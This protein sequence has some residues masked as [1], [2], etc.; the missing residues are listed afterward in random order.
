MSDA[1]QI[2]KDADGKAVVRGR[3]GE[4]FLTD[5]AN[6]RRL[7]DRGDVTAATADQVHAH[8]D[9]EAG[10]AL[11]AAGRGVA[12]GVAGGLLSL[13]KAVTAATSYATGTEDPL[14]GLS[15]R[16]FVEDVRAIGTELGGGDIVQ[17][18]NEARADI[19]RDMALHPVA[20]HGGEIAGQIGGSA[21]Y[22]AG[23][24]GL[25]KAATAKAGLQGVAAVR[26][27]HLAAGALEG[28]A[29]GATAVAEDAWLRDDVAT[30]EHTLA[31]MGVGALF[32]VGVA[33][34]LMGLGVGAK[35][36]TK[37]FGRGANAADGAVAGAA[38]DL[39]GKTALLEETAERVGKLEQVTEKASRKADDYFSGLRD[40]SAVSAVARQDQKAMREI[41]AHKNPEAARKVGRTLME[42]GIVEKWSSA[43]DTLK[44]A[45]SVAAKSGQ[46]VGDVIAQIQKHGGFVNGRA[47]FQK[48]DEHIDRFRG[49]FTP[50]MEG[51]A[52]QLDDTV[53][54]I[55]QL[56]D[57][58]ALE[59][60]QLHQFRRELDKS[61]KWASAAKNPSQDALK[62]LRG[63]V[64]DQIE[65]EV[66][67]IG[68]ESGA[69]GLLK[70]YERAK[71]IFRASRWAEETLSRQVG[72][73]SP[74]NR[75]LSLTDYGVGLTAAASMGP[76]GAL[77]GGASALGHKVLRE[78]G[79]G[80]VAHM[81]SKRARDA[82][83]LVA[84]PASAHK[85]ARSLRAVMGHVDEKIAHHVT[86]F[87]S[88]YDG[89]ERAA[90]RLTR[91]AGAALLEGN[92]AERRSAYASHAEQVAKLASMPEVAAAE[93]A[94]LTGQN[95]PA[96]APRLNAQMAATVARAA[97]YLQ[98]HAPAPARDPSSLTP[99]LDEPPPVSDGD[100]Y[101]Y[102][103]RVEG[104]T[105]PL[106]LLEDIESGDVDPVKV[107]AVKAV[108]PQVFD[109]IRAKIFAEL[110]LRTSPVPP[111]AR[112]ILDIALD[113]NGAI[114][115]SQAPRFLQ[116]MR[117]AGQQVQQ[118]APRP[119]SGPAPSISK[120]L[121]T[122]S[123]RIASL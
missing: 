110:T 120:S 12:S 60:T 33:G 87:F 64:E 44:R 88:H 74:A 76:M 79:A 36:L 37:L 89:G 68:Q 16:Q 92:Y 61:I 2:I 26:A 34:G 55:R 102:A 70:E 40:D 81:A 35:G 118:S 15:G 5:E 43:A 71:N 67:R 51:I 80:F 48:V 95:L 6:A 85:T 121:S 117:D 10:G 42:T 123:E 50:E 82:V 98:A 21:V 46:Q 86:E 24:G 73:R 52:G 99:H 119:P 7:I 109:G 28:G 103:M 45:E 104:V 93:L 4:L 32:G 47:L 116:T 23:L 39:A 54:K 1:P 3:G 101:E 96:V 62:E 13:P 111:E 100:L 63:I 31:G 18:A 27:S 41:G 11:G 57:V 90:A 19:E 53:A 49:G 58:G 69:S 59:Q 83:D 9:V 65:A 30:A 20:F 106:S 22:G 78:R 29:L 25:A 97:S 113:A 115:P 84:A 66:S 108:W 8:N 14:A 114:E 105:E 122:R 56:S 38:D 94:G 75:F 107:E 112:K 72:Q 91:R 77:I 17:G